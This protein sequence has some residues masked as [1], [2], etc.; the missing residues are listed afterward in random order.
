MEWALQPFEGNDAERFK[1][2]RENEKPMHRSLDCSIMEYADDIAYGVHDLEDIVGR[3]LV[4]QREVVEHVRPVFDSVGPRIGPNGKAV[5]LRDFEETLFGERDERKSLI[6]KLVNLFITSVQMK[7]DTSFSHPLLRYRC[8]IAGPIR[9]LMKS[10]KDLTPK[11]VIQQAEVQQLE[12]RGVRIVSQLFEALN[13]DPV[14]LIPEA[15]WKWFSE[16][17]PQ[18]RRVCDYVAGMTDRYAERIYERLFVPGRGSS[19][20]EL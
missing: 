19:R 13:S 6:G 18:S 16:A 17:D 7:Q 10:L 8:D 1:N 5:S 11:L 14:K 3:H 12:A 15:S 2:E 20:D 9:E 4:S